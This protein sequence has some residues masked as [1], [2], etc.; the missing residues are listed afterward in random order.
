[1]MIQKKKIL[2]VAMEKLIIL[3]FR[4]VCE[5]KIMSSQS[6]VE[7]CLLAQEELT[8]FIESKLSLQDEI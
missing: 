1:M 2:L 7:V 6:I 3:R 5:N 4:S 8:R